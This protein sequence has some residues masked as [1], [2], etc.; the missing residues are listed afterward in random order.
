MRALLAYLLGF[1]AY[2]LG[3]WEE[4]R[5]RRR[6]AL[7]EREQA[8]HRELLYFH[9]G[10]AHACHHALIRMRREFNE[11]CLRAHSPSPCQLDGSRR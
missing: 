2:W 9:A 4:M 8:Y 6:I 5:A 10:R 3:C 11:R 7:V 1:R